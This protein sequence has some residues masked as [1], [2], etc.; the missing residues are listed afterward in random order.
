[1]KKSLFITALIAVL[2]FAFQSADACTSFL[3]G[4]KASTDG[5]AFITYN[6]DSYGMFGRLK[7]YPAAKH[8]KGTM[9]RIVDGDTNHYLCDIPEA[10][11]TYA[12]MGQINEYQ[13]A[14]TET[15]FGGR[16]ELDGAGEGIDYVSLMTLGLQRAK[17]AREA[18]KVMTELVNKYGYASS[19]ESFSIADPNEVWI[20]EMI[21]KGKG[22]EGAVWV[23]VRIPDD[24]IAAHANH[25]RIH[26]FN[27][28]DKDNVMYAKDV[29][30]FA[31]QKGYFTG[32]DADFSFST[33]YAPAD[34][35]AIRYCDTRVWS[36]YNKWVEGMDQYL[37]YATGKA[38]GKHEPM[39][40]YFK[41]K[42]K[43][44][45]ADV[46]ESNRDH[47]EGTP[48]DI[49]KDAGAGAYCMPYRPSPL[50]WKHEGKTYFNERPIST[51]QTAFTVVAQVRDYLPNAIG[52][53][54][55]YAND[56]PN[57]AAYTP[58]YCANNAVPECYNVAEADD[59]TFSIK[60]AFWVCNWVANMTYP[61]YSQ[62]F[63]SLKAVRDRLETTY[64]DRAKQIEGTAGKLFEHNPADAVKYLTTYSQ[65]CSEEMMSAWLKLAEY[66]IVKFNDMVVKP[67]KDGKF[68]LT[69]DGIAVPPVRPGFDESQKA[70][71]V[72]ETGD[73][74]LLPTE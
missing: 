55:W 3:V 65:Q 53:V 37:Y 17:T 59:V 66:Q 47:Y 32:K 4:K 33:T 31:R 51:Q 23:A 18:I 14:I 36:F 68:E 24:C 44:S 54:L 22:R 48:F 12:V 61:R 15:T 63:P 34:F 35:G 9:R 39:P 13:L 8:P 46:M 49:T 6:A 41:P 10:A 69:P 56:D 50:T 25:S 19:G 40:L 38:I 28:K 27:L 1:M 30:T 20:M 73:K 2:T 58:V 57:M 29:I 74:Y 11:E 67:E 52:G 71:I 64:F 45:L 42:C 16:E 72:R 60:S 70:T 26:K 5:S 21:G 43:L 62:M 7:Y